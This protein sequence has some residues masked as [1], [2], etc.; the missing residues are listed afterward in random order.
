[1]TAR[2]DLRFA[3]PGRVGNPHL[4]A[5][6]SVTEVPN[7]EVP[8]MPDTR[9]ERTSQHP[10][11]RILMEPLADRAPAPTCGQ[12]IRKRLGGDGCGGRQEKWHNHREL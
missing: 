8:L 4:P 11:V 1:M 10:L 2:L 6:Q 9:R 12:W 5:G 7:V 3:G